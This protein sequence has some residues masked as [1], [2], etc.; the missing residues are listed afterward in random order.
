MPTKKVYMS[1]TMLMLKLKQ[2][3][4]AIY[5]IKS[6]PRIFAYAYPCLYNKFWGLFLSTYC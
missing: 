2:K 6:F 4:G 3:R 5:S 1:C